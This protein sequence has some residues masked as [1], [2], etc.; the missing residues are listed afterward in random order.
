MSSTSLSITAAWRGLA[1]SSAAA[2]SRNIENGKRICET[3]LDLAKGLDRGFVL[4][5][6]RFELANTSFKC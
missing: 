3:P 6:L 5:D 1:F 2:F 4:R